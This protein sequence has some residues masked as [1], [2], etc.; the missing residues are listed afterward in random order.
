[1]SQYALPL[2][3]GKCG[4]DLRINGKTVTKVNEGNGQSVYSE[5]S[6]NATEWKDYCIKVKLRFNKTESSWI[7]VGIV[8]NCDRANDHLFY[9][10]RGAQTN[11]R[12]YSKENAVYL[13]HCQTGAKS[14]SDSNSSVTDKKWIKHGKYSDNNPLFNTNDV[15]TFELNFYKKYIKIHENN[16]LI[17]NNS[18]FNNIDDFVNLEY[19]LAV[20]LL[21]E[22]DCIELVQ[23]SAINLNPKTN[24]NE[25][26]M[27]GNAH[28][29]KEYALR[30]EDDDP[31]HDHDDTFNNNSAMYFKKLIKSKDLDINEL[32]R[33]LQAEKQKRYFTSQSTA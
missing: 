10:V 8:G 27:F 5:Q 29:E 28:D 31:K 12:E 20:N 2:T 3:W 30:S 9:N 22:N 15:I 6:F 25:M 16:K 26:K 21:H 11:V 4:D 19:Y 1:M 14:K 13:I 32:K 33:Q 23:C 7:R 24:S 18:M 17:D